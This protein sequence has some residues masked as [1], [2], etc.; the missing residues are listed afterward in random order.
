MKHK[1]CSWKCFSLGI[2][3]DFRHRAIDFHFWNW[4]FST[5]NFKYSELG[6]DY[7]DFHFEL[8]GKEEEWIKEHYPG[9]HPI[10]M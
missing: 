3:I 7:W 8:M 9:F 2:H 4:F 5:S 10:V 1:T 6:K